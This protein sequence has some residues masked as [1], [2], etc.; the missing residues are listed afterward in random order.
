MLTLVDTRVYY[1]VQQLARVS[2]RD[3]T[4]IPRRQLRSN[5]F[6]TRAMTFYS[7]KGIHKKKMLDT[8]MQ[9]C[10]FCHL[11]PPPQVTEHNDIGA[12][13]Q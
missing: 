11:L 5:D 10:F 1:T 4:K 6:G 2:M 3:Y 13:S 7:L 9:I 12:I 8:Q